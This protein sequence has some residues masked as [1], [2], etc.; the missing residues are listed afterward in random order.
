MLCEGRSTDMGFALCNKISND[1]FET[2]MALTCCKDFLND[3][4]ALE[5]N[6]SLD[7]F[8]VYGFKYDRKLGAIK[9]KDKC[10]FALRSLNN[11][12]CDSPINKENN[13][14][15]IANAEN[16]ERF[17]NIVEKKYNLSESIVTIVDDFLIIEFDPK[18]ANT[19][20]TIS[21]YSLLLRIGQY[22]DN[23]GDILDYLTKGVGYLHGD[24]TYA[25][26]A[27]NLIKTVS[28]E[29]LSENNIKPGM[30][31][32]EIHNYGICTF[33]SLREKI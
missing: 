8:S 28:F 9:G 21:M 18:W 16:L 22:W 24:R 32:H 17:I 11:S 1:T 19:T 26:T 12:R 4:V 30:G 29:E 25:Q 27:S 3:A 14:R 10:Y 5:Q 13:N 2:T 31:P 20:V 6:E 7:S 33:A 15:M 23:K